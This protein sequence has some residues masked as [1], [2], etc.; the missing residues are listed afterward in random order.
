M[1]WYIYAIAGVSVQAMTN[2][3]RRRVMSGQKKLDFYTSSYLFSL[4]STLALLVYVAIAGFIMPPIFSL[5]PIVV[6]NIAFGIIAWLTNNKALSLL[7]L[8]DYSIVMTSR[9][10]FTWVASVVVLGVGLNLAQVAGVVI[11]VAGILILFVGKRRIKM[12]S[13]LGV[14]FALATA[15]IYGFGI[16]TDQIIYR[17]SDPASYLLVGFIVTT[18]VIGVMRPSVFSSTKLLFSRKHALKLYGF[19]ALSAASLGL[20]FTSLKL[21]DNAPL[22]TAIFQMQTV[23][24]VLLGIIL[25]KENGHIWQKLSGAAISTIGAVIVVVA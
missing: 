20:M 17:S 19:G 14:V 25:L 8:G 1:P 6:I 10:F 5:W 9:Q 24:A 15:L 12:N 23:L 4:T 22:V 18:F 7:N 2:V 13:R 11:I 16:I 21:A 3:L